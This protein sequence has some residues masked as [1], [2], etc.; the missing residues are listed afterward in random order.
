MWQKSEQ[1]RLILEGLQKPTWII[2]ME[3]LD[4]EMKRQLELKDRRSDEETRR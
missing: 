4:E 3:M 2:P 1:T